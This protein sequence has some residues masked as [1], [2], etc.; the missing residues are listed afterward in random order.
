[1]E[2]VNKKARV[3]TTRCY[4]V[5]SSDA[6]WNRLILDLN[7]AAEAMGRGIDKLREIASAL[8]AVFLGFCT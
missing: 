8:K 7:R 6:L 5:K 4:R 2:G 1:V 3:I